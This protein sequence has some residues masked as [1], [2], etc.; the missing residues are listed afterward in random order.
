M[1]QKGKSF[2][3]VSQMLTF[4]Y[5]D[6]KCWVEISLRRKEI[7]HLGFLYWQTQVKEGL[8]PLAEFPVFR[9]KRRI[10]TGHL[11]GQQEN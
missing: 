5:V 4:Q 11:T 7:N 3:M 1:V 8:W 2:E 9:L 6:R 10:Q